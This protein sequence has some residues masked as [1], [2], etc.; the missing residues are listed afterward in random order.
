MRKSGTA[1]VVGA[2]A[3]AMLVG[4]CAAFG[5]QSA[6]SESGGADS[7]ATA[8]A[9]TPRQFTFTYM[10]FTTKYS[11]DGLADK[12][13]SILLTLG[14]RKED[15]HVTQTGCAG[16]LGHPV[17]F[18][19][20]NVRMSVLTPAPDGT[21]QA[22]WKSVQLKTDRDPINASGEC[23]LLEQVKQRVLPLFSAKGTELNATC[24]P[25]QLSAGGASLQA[26]VLTA[27]APRKGS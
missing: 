23:E 6:A 1:V 13:K 20:V 25:H 27:P 5:E 15:L 26:Q 10:G 7:T 17:P 8:A 21:V 3:V 18:P 22:Q 19:G 24:V 11:C 9:W 4:S 12:V 16:Q 14:A 2:T